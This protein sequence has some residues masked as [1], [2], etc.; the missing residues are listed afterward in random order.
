MASQVGTISFEIGDRSGSGRRRAQFTVPLYNMEVT[1]FGVT[2][3]LGFKSGIVTQVLVGRCASGRFG[4]D[5][6]DAEYHEGRSA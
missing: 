6:H 1:S 5:D 2:A 3:E 4:V